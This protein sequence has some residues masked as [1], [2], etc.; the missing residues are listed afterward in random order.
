MAISVGP[1]RHGPVGMSQFFVREES[2]FLPKTPRLRSTETQ[3]SYAM[4][5]EVGDMID[6][7]VKTLCSIFIVN[8]HSFI[9]VQIRPLEGKVKCSALFPIIQLS[10]IGVSVEAGNQQISLPTSQIIITYFLY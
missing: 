10:I 9:A 7:R 3:L 4:I 1:I 6:D 5:V 2:R 8:F